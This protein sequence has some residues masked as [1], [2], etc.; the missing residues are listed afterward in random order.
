MNQI[1]PS[2]ELLNKP[3]IK[4]KRKAEI[5]PVKNQSKLEKISDTGQRNFTLVNLKMGL[6]YVGTY[7]STKSVSADG[8]IY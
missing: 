3:T 7:R 8:L 6:T 4:A 5:K 1:K 2:Q